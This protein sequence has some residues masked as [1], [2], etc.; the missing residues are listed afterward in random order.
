MGC[1]NEELPEAI[2]LP[3]VI[4]VDE[5]YIAGLLFKFAVPQLDP[6]GFELRIPVVRGPRCAIGLNPVRPN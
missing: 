6:G 1:A 3:G 4:G 5:P 2:G